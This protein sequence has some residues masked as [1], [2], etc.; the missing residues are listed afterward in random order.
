MHNLLH[1]ALL[2]LPV[3]AHAF[4][5]PSPEVLY[6]QEAINNCI[7]GWVH[8]SYDFSPDNRAINI[9]VVDSEPTGVFEEAAI[10]AL[11]VFTFS[12]EQVR[13]RKNKEYVFRYILGE[14]ETREACLQENAGA[15]QI[16]GC[17]Y[18]LDFSIQF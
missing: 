4:V 11:S 3:L 1:A 13:N 12:D 9:R 15:I 5:G 10:S 6:P 18:R 17:T 2:M 8:R 7:E 14:N 16:P